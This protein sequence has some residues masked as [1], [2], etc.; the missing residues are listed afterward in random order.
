MIG[1]YY[2]NTEARRM[3]A[4]GQAC[5]IP[6]AKV[7]IDSRQFAVHAEVQEAFE[8]WEEVRQ[9]Y[10]YPLTGEDTGAYNCRHINH[11]PNNPWSAHAWATAMDTNWLENPYG[12]KLVTDI[13]PK[14]VE[15]LQRLRTGS[16]AYV[17]MWGGDW[18]RKPDTPHAAYDAMH[19]EVIAHPLDLAT[20][21]AL[22]SSLVK[23]DELGLKLG[24]RGNA[25]KALQQALNKWSPALALTEDGIFGSRTEAALKTYQAAAQVPESGILDIYTAPF[26]MTNEIRRHLA[27]L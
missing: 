6:F 5:Q 12:S 10:N 8:V 20:G 26:I 17:F 25:V 19:W 24:D 23:G 14:M 11:N 16:G 3:A 13:P 7:T 22:D 15:E 18:D 4:W 21:I 1:P 27:T 9:K 2:V